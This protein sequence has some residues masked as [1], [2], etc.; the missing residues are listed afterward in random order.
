MPSSGFIPAVGTGRLGGNGMHLSRRL[1]LSLLAG[2]AVFSGILAVYQTEA[3]YGWSRQSLAMTLGGLPDLAIIAPFW[4]HILV[5]V[6]EAL[7]VVGLTL[8]IVRWSLGRP[9]RQMAQWL[10]DM[11]TGKAS[12][13]DKPPEEEIF[14]PLTSEVRAAR[15]QPERWPARRRKKRPG[16]ANARPVALDSG[17]AAHLG[18]G[19]N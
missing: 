15:H 1:I 6:L 8:M 12:A 11:R 2:V 14:R 9:L 19:A 16:C 5:S 4:R 18:A 13:E 3:I 10:R 17:A 7:F